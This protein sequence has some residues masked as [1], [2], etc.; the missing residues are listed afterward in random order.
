MIKKSVELANDVVFKYIETDKFKTNYFSFNFIS[1]LVSDK[2]AY[3]SLLPLV[4]MRGCEKYPTQADINKKLQYLYSGEIVARNDAFGEYQ[5]FGLKANMLDNRYSQG[6]DVT[7]ETVDLI[8]NMLFK[9]LLENGVFSEKYTRGE[10]INLIDIIESER[11]NKT[12]YSMERLKEEMCQNEVFGISKLGKVENV[13]KITPQSLYNAY[14]EILSTYPIEIY[15][16]GK[17]DFEKLSNMLASQFNS[18]GRKP[19]TINKVKTIEKATNVKQIVD[20]EN[21]KQGKLCLGF[22]T[23][24]K[25]EDNK[26]Y[27]LQLFN[28]VFGGS[29]TSKLFMNVR[30]KMSLCYYCRSI[31]NQRNGIMIVAS[32]IEF[33]NKEIAENAIIEQLNA[34]KNGDITLE[35]FE[36][37][38]KSIR[39]GYLQVYD[40]AESMETW[41]FFRG[42][43]GSNATPTDECDKIDT[44]T[45]NDIKNVAAKMTLDTVYFL[46]G[47][48]KS[49]VNNG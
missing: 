10:K 37:A 32:G 45:I 20:I 34:I 46:K 49:E 23:G 29:P 44:A 13:Q 22:R 24:Y 25:V 12:K 11:N 15:F 3:N 17:C 43:C 19:I 2:T 8:C 31:V 21:V 27:L 38:R 18:I 40:S 28:E 35:E 42:L 9:P 5:I 1:P 39:N 41:A 7:M 6:T 4:L 36:S 16:V 33:S 14:K 47:I 26:Y 30:E 48:E